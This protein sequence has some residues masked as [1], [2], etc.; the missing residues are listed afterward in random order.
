MASEHPAHPTYAGPFSAVV[1]ARLARAAI[2]DLPLAAT[3]EAHRRV[4][5]QAMS[6]QRV[7]SHAPFWEIA[8]GVEAAKATPMHLRARWLP[9]G[10]QLALAYAASV[11]VA[12][13]EEEQEP[14]VPPVAREIGIR[15]MAETQS[16]FVIG[17]GHALVNVAARA[18]SLR[19]DQGSDY[20]DPL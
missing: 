4:R 18:L 14:D 19:Q 7:A 13:W 6:W 17:T 3:D 12:L 9:P 11:E 8:A 16:L 5:E 15:A 10:E 20:E 1:P 2:R